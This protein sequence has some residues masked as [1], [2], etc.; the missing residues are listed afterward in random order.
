MTPQKRHQLQLNGVLSDRHH[1][2][3]PRMEFWRKRTALPFN[4]FEGACTMVKKTIACPQCRA[5]IQ[6]GK[7]LL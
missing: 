4:P 2:T 7:F 1:P 5:Q 6:V 3:Q